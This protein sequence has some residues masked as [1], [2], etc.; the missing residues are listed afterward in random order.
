MKFWSPSSEYIK[1]VWDREREITGPL[2][3]SKLEF[4]RLRMSQI[5]GRFWRADHSFKLL[6]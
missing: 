4:Q 5:V 6:K 2:G 1:N 3:M